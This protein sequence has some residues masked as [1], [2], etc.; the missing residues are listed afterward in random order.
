MAM[1]ASPTAYKSVIGLPKS[2]ASTFTRNKANGH[3]VEE[4]FPNGDSRRVRLAVPKDAP[5]RTITRRLKRSNSL[6]KN[7][8][9]PPIRRTFS[10]RR[11]PT[12]ASTSSLPQVKVSDS[13]GHRVPHSLQL[14]TWESSS[15]AV[16]PTSLKEVPFEEVTLRKRLTKIAA[17]R[18]RHSA[19]LTPTSYSSSASLQTS[20]ISSSRLE[21]SA[22]LNTRCA[23]LHTIDAENDSCDDSDI[24]S[25]VA[26]GE[27]SPSQRGSSSH[28][29][30]GQ[31]TPAYLNVRTPETA[32]K[33]VTFDLSKP[34]SPLYQ[35]VCNQWDIKPESLS[36]QEKVN[37]QNHCARL[38]QTSEV[39][40]EN[41]FEMSPLLQSYLAVYRT[42]FSDLFPSVCNFTKKA[43]PLWPKD[44]IDSLTGK[45]S[46]F[47][48]KHSDL[49]YR[50]L[51]NIEST[52]EHGVI[53]EETIN[54]MTYETRI[55]ELQDLKQL[56]E[57]VL[58]K[59][60]VISYYTTDLGLFNS[61]LKEDVYNLNIRLNAMITAIQLLQK[62]DFR[63]KSNWDYCVETIT[64]I[65]SCYLDKCKPHKDLIKEQEKFDTW[66]S[67]REYPRQGVPNFI[68][69]LKGQEKSLVKTLAIKDKDFKACRTEVLS[70]QKAELSY[71][72]FYYLFENQFHLM[73]ILHK[74]AGCMTFGETTG[75]CDALGLGGCNIPS[76]NPAAEREFNMMTTFV[77]VGDNQIMKEVRGGVPYAFKI[78]DLDKRT[79]VTE[80]RFQDIL[81]ACGITYFEDEMLS[82]FYPEGTSSKTA[83]GMPVI[84][85]CLLS[86]DKL[87]KRAQFIIPED[88]REWCRQIAL[89]IEELN[90]SVVKLPIQKKDGTKG[91]VNVQP[92]ILF[93]VNPCNQLSHGGYS[94][95]SGIWADADQYNEQA[96]LHLF[97]VLN[98]N[99]PITADCYMQKALD[100]PNLAPEIKQELKELSQQLRYIYIH[101]LHHNLDAQPFLFANYISELGRI[102]NM[103]V[104]SGCKSAKDRTGN[105]ERCNI[106]IA[107]QLHLARERFKAK[108]HATAEASS[109]E[110]ILPPVDQRMTTDNLYNSTGLLISSGQMEIAMRNLCI[111][112]FKV[113]DYM[114]GYAKG[115]Y[116]AINAHVTAQK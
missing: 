17:D 58:T 114:L 81:T 97:G 21:L 70:Q 4:H 12:T 39:I 88:E 14:R 107:M 20:P 84:Y 10:V 91:F 76:C 22:H 100:N 60:E 27:S 85:N 101:K 49:F 79:Q 87:R 47:Q 94:L 110:R 35:A 65:G 109:S 82:H 102:M 56:T 26:S 69:R 55:K 51:D 61:A 63:T 19:L 33:L 103:A 1:A 86:P 93:F 113:P 34:R 116:P 2:H 48:K 57:E 23:E 72:D 105:Y 13:Q 106:E 16:S 104:F 111:P 41:D 24:T 6:T 71:K 108:L 15:A 95:F 54:Q 45:E 37:I 46:G 62:N 78:D 25:T 50:L 52:F 74:P 3:I 73:S 28:L 53:S 83:F 64:D 38:L 31:H 92:D 59:F 29:A 66:K 42:T 80:K 5:E 99:E 112:G 67:L 30:S 115:V 40:P 77:T 43:P 11:C 90:K 18:R 68:S 98:P 75:D 96:F 7:T 32:Q 44:V 9:R 8:A 36:R 89:H